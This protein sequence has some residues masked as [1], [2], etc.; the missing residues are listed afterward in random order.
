MEKLVELNKQWLN[1]FGFFPKNKDKLKDKTI[2]VYCEDLNINGDDTI[3]FFI[4]LCESYITNIKFKLCSEID[5]IDKFNDIDYYFFVSPDYN[6]RNNQQSNFIT[7]NLF[8]DKIYFLK[9][10]KYNNDVLIEQINIKNNNDLYA[11]EFYNRMSR[12]RCYKEDCVEG[13]VDKYK[14]LLTNK[15]ILV[16]YQYN[17]CERLRTLFYFVDLI[18]DKINFDYAVCSNY[19]EFKSKLND[20]DVIFIKKEPYYYQLYENEINNIATP[21]GDGIKYLEDIKKE[22]PNNKDVLV[23]T[24]E[25]DYIDN[26]G[27]CEIIRTN[28]DYTSWLI[29]FIN[30]IEDY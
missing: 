22:I 19:Q 18:R 14:D 12:K 9:I 8:N 10:Q 29:R 17:F 11:L 26:V 25:Y 13:F 15:K 24:E 20:Y 5:L 7:E 1:T 6:K 30:R 16:Y 27:L 21:I 23:F 3:N 4:K 2:L 28:Y